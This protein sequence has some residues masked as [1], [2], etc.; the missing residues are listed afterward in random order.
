MGL[1][2]GLKVFEEVEDATYSGENFAKRTEN[3]IKEGEE[4]Y[5]VAANAFALEHGFAS[6]G[7]MAEEIKSLRASVDELIEAQKG[8][9]L[10][11]MGKSGENLLEAEGEAAE[12]ISRMSKFIKSPIGRAGKF[13]GKTAWKYKKGIGALSGAAYLYNE[14][15]LPEYDELKRDCQCTCQGFNKLILNDEKWEQLNKILYCRHNDGGAPCE[16]VNGECPT[17]CTLKNNNKK[18]AS[19]YGITNPSSFESDSPQY[20]DWEGKTDNML[21]PLNNDSVV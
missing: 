6:A 2:G 5:E 8:F 13:L 15:A 9:K 1:K 7:H 14:Y 19:L 18:S 12:N 4:I 16:L 21:C 11:N 20:T 17:G 3:A 10:S